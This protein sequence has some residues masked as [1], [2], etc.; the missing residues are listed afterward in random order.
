MIV[1]WSSSIAI[2]SIRQGEA[3][4]SNAPTNFS[5]PADKNN[6]EFM[7]SDINYQSGMFAATLSR[8]LAARKLSVASTRKC[9]IKDSANTLNPINSSNFTH[10]LAV[11]H[12][13][14]FVALG[15]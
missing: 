2:A 14:D 7:P 8:V 13:R 12:L 10:V 15:R 11:H 1:C 5:K 9:S 6:P 3:P 4:F